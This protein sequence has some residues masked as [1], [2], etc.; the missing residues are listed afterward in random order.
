MMSNLKRNI[1]PHSCGS[2]DVIRAN[3]VDEYTATYV[4]PVQEF[5]VAN[6]ALPPQTTYNLPILRDGSILLVLSG[7]CIFTNGSQEPVDAQEVWF[8]RIKYM[9]TIQLVEQGS[10]LFIGAGE[11][12]TVQS[13]H[14]P[15]QLSRA[16]VNQSFDAGSCNVTC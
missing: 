15:A 12:V 6:T 8:L 11:S 7:H 14:E 5:E 13:N 3:H 2:A 4:P 16:S 10:I 1:A 9:H